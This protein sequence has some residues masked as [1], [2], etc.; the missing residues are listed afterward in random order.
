MIGQIYL[1]LEDTRKAR[2]AFQR[3]LE[4]MP[5]QERVH[6]ILNRLQK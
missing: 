5:S 6:K 1:K 3:S 4:I 2:E